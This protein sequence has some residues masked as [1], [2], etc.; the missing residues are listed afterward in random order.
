ME[1]IKQNI[2]HNISALRRSVSLTQLGLAEEL[3]YSDKAISKWERGESIPDVTVL[4]LIADRFG[5]TVDY[6][7]C[8]HT[9]TVKTVSQPHEL[10]AV[11]NKNRMLISLQANAAVWLVATIIFVI[12][13]LTTHIADLWKIYV[14]AIPISCIVA[15]VF[16]S[17]WGNY[18]K[19][20]YLI[21]SVLVW[22]ILFCIFIIFFKYGVASIFYI[23]IPAQIIILLWSRL[24]RIKL[25]A[26]HPA[27][28]NIIEP[29]N[30]NQNEENKY[31]K[32]EVKL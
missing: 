13:N 31:S 26:T 4:K 5:V 20:N 11:K 17:M 1:D 2:A 22:S 6:L 18:K 3:N 29:Q 28:E 21:V 23:G 8:E 32:R 27:Q 25:I 19:L 9:E 16:N 30:L 12:L 7:L 10:T 14:F 24:S 15:L